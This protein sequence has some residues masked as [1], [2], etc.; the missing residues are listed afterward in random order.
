[1]RYE[2]VY[3]LTLE[4]PSM[5][6][7]PCFDTTVPAVLTHEIFQA[8]LPSA[9][10]PGSTEVPGPCSF[11][12]QDWSSCCSLGCLSCL[13]FG[14]AFQWGTV[15]KTV[16]LLC[17]NRVSLPDIFLMPPLQHKECRQ[18]LAGWLTP[19]THSHYGSQRTFIN[20][21]I[22]PSNPSHVIHKPKAWK[23]LCMN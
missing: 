2:K 22:C 8:E 13:T 10:S 18:E 5:A 20:H 4:L 6:S 21:P 9:C 3:A 23:Q 7:F 17:S 16:L 15:S 12:V 1:M 11:E 14:E 19:W